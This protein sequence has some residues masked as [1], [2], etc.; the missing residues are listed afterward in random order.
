MPTKRRRAAL[1]LNLGGAEDEHLEFG[2]G[3]HLLYETCALCS[4]DRAA[5]AHAWRLR[6]DDII[7]Q[8]R[9]PFPTWAAITLDGARLPNRPD[10]NA[11]TPYAWLRKATSAD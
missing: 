11:W 7:R 2:P 10:W 8:W 5:I 9:F 6:R 3:A 4:G 1:A